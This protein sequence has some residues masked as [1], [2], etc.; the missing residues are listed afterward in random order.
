MFLLRFGTHLPNC[1]V[2]HPKERV[3]QEYKDLR[4]LQRLLLALKLEVVGSSET[5]VKSYQTARCHITEDS[6]CQ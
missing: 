2:S 3:L 5:F 6:N 4:Y 1:M